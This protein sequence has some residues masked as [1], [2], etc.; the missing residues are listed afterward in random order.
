MKSLFV[1]VLFVGLVI[2]LAAYSKKESRI[3]YCKYV[4]SNKTRFDLRSLDK[5]TQKGFL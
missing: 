3:C 1:L 2:F 5:A 4:N